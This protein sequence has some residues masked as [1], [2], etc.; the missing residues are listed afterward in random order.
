M[1]SHQHILL[2][3]AH[4][5]VFPSNSK[6]L[7]GQLLP[8]I[9]DPNKPQIY[10]IHVEKPE[11]S[12]FLG[13]EDLESW[14]KS[15]LPNTTLD[16]G[17]PR[18]V[19]SYRHAISGFA[20]RLT[21]EEVRAIEAMDGFLAATPDEESEPQTTYTPQ[22]LGLSQWTNGTWHQTMYGEGIIIG[23]VDRGLHPNH[24]SFR[25]HGMPPPPVRWKGSCNFTGFG[26]NNKIIGAATF[27]G[28]KQPSQ[29]PTDDKGHGTHVA[30][31]AG[32]NFVS[33]ASVLGSAG[34]TASGMAPKSHLAIYKASTRAD[35]LGAIDQA[36]A[37]GVDVL[38]LS[39]G[40]A[41]KTKFFESEVSIGLHA[42]VEHGIPA[43][44]S[45]GNRGSDWQSL[46]F[47]A[48][49]LIG[50]GA[51]AT[52]RRIMATVKLGNGIEIEG[53][54]AFQPTTF[55][56]SILLP[57]VFPGI[58]GTYDDEACLDEYTLDK[59]NVRGK[60]VLCV[61]GWGGEG[62]VAKG[63][64]LYEAGAA[65]MI[66]VGSVYRGTDTIAQPHVLPVSHVNYVDAQKILC[67]V[68]SMK[69]STPTAT[70]I[71]HGA[72]FGHR[73]SPQLASFSSRGPSK[74]NGGILKPD[75][76]APG[77]NILGAWR[78]P[79]GFGNTAPFTFSSGTSMAAP[80]V[81]GIVA[82]LKNKH[83]DWSPA[84][85]QSAIMTSATSLDLDGNP[86]IDARTNEPADVYGIGAGHV[87]PWAAMDPGLVYDLNTTRYIDYLCGL[88]YTDDEVKRTV[89]RT[90]NCSTVHKIAASDLN[91]P[92]IGV[93]L[94]S[95]IASANFTRV[96]TNVGQARS[97]YNA[98]IT[99][100]RGVRVELSEYQ[101]QF[102]RLRQT[103]TFTVKL[104]LKNPRP[105]KIR[106][107][108]GK[109]EW[110]SNKYVVT[111]PI[112]VDFT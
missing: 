60:I 53:E 7:T 104:S 62:N 39:I 88:G 80:H 108:G 47:H 41:T 20:A 112:A 22:F 77:M 68:Y 75:I 5:L 90:V 1:E 48:P 97:T 12:V 73:P 85:I 40:R 19:Y 54:S 18:L 99:E 105:G 26:C 6:L 92:S 61:V 24:P 59:L 81:A 27:N 36:I 2:L 66:L 32:G 17:E 74:I 13:D 58:D 4:L 103:V 70:I 69:N 106:N 56:S 28:G 78:D 10:I 64:R 38:T 76:I 15:F 72:R 14:H 3:L 16:S 34:G 82:L 65:G 11:G 95:S 89:R 71:F 107:A 79:P 86:I 51:S 42:A 25:D 109:L 31:I 23:V 37:D 96:V 21:P 50:V 46:D 94:N 35:V 63:K 110:V 101:L 111:S 8:V 55:N 33:N 93:S 98:R 45:L 67:Y 43:I 91:Y 44:C 83:P 84:A 29:P 9:E 52:D 102:S 57:L 87:R 100:P 49:W 30:S